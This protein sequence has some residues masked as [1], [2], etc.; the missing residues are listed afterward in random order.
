MTGVY[1]ERILACARRQGWLRNETRRV[2]RGAMQQPAA[3]TWPVHHNYITYLPS[4]FPA[5]A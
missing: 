5:F 1:E 3:A 4:P 2:A